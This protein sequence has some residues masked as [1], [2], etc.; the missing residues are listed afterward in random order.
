M[1]KPIVQY[2]CMECFQ[3]YLSEQTAIDCENEHS[4]LNDFKIS[5]LGTEIFKNDEF[6]KFINVENLKSKTIGRYMFRY[7]KW[8]VNIDVHYKENE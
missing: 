1:P 2:Q 7:K 5:S 3:T 8:P 6:P 4:K